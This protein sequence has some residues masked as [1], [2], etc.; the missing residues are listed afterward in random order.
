MLAAGI[1]FLL[2][3]AVLAVFALGNM[4]LEVR[5]GYYEGSGASKKGLLGLYLLLVSGL[6]LGAG[7][8]YR[9]LSAS[10]HAREMR[11]AAAAILGPFASGSSDAKDNFVVAGQ[12]SGLVEKLGPDLRAGS[13][14]CIVVIGRVDPRVLEADVSRKYESNEGLAQARALWVKARLLEGLTP[15]LE[16][17][18]ITVLSAGPRNVVARTSPDTLATDR[19]VEVYLCLSK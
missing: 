6:V 8:F 4:A 3:T 17:A 14:G 2:V 9:N 12:L 15:N 11:F 1:A 10:P 13:I 19:I 16:P 7:F 18:R 5:K